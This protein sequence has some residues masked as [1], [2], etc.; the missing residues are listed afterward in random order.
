ME[1]ENK[2]TRISDEAVK[3]A[4]EELKAQEQKHDVLHEVNL[5]PQEVDA[6]QLSDSEF[7]QVQYRFMNDTLTFMN[8][9]TTILNDIEIILL[10][11]ETPYKK[12]RL[13]KA[14]NDAGEKVQATVKDA[15]EKLNQTE[16]KKD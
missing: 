15:K 14:L 12:E 10:E 6:R 11:R 7:K 3:K 5:R 4:N 16:E 13:M 9:I 1:L 2:S 8:Y